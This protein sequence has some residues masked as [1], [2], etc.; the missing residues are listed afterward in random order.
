MLVYC[1]FAG[2]QT[3][4][5][6]PE[7]SPFLSSSDAS[8]FFS[9][10]CTR[11][12]TTANRQ[13]LWNQLLSH[14]FHG[15]GGCAPVGLSNAPTSKSSN[16]FRNYPLFFNLLRTLLLS[17]AFSCTFQKI[18]SFIFK[19]FRTLCQKTQGW[20]TFSLPILSLPGACEP[21]G[22]CL[23]FFQLSTFN[24]QLSTSSVRHSSIAHGTPVT[25]HP[26][27]GGALSSVN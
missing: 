19:L 12:F 11:S 8:L 16:A 6:L 7:L 5:S 18:N 4:S 13:P 2:H 15:D 3:R 27:A 10:D 26:L 23:Q 17:F 22:E 25:V 14:C 20:G 21:A 24:L 9:C 1:V